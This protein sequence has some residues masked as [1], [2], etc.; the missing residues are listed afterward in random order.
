MVD[1]CVFDV[2]NIYTTKEVNISIKQ[3]HDYSF[4]TNSTF[5]YIC[6]VPHIPLLYNYVD[7]SEIPLGTLV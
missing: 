1:L 4:N 2:I 3:Q 5:L 6:S 7:N